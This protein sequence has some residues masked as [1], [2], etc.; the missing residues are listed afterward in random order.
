MYHDFRKRIRSAL[1]IIQY[2]DEFSQQFPSETLESLSLLVGQYGEISDL[3]VKLELLDKKQ[4][5]K[6]IEKLHQKIKNQWKN[7]QAWEKSNNISQVLNDAQR[8]VQEF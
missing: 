5:Q 1:K 4:D 3:I 7:I 8:A 2:F 6:K